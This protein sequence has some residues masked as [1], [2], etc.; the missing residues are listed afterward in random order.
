MPISIWKNLVKTRIKEYDRNSH[1]LTSAMYIKSVLF[2]K[3]VTKVKMWPW[4]IHASRY[5]ELA[6]HCTTL[7]RILLGMETESTDYK[8]ISLC[9]CEYNQVKTVEH[10]LFV[11]K[12]LKSS[13][14]HYWKSVV[15]LAPKRLFDD[16]NDMSV[17]SKT[18]FLISGFG[19][20]YVPEF[21]L[22]YT[23][24]LMYIIQM[25]KCSKP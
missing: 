12:K 18:I 3:C 20:T 14:E 9:D 1:I 11:C 19:G 15:K 6:K 24:V 4:Y 16:L 21:H 2:V 13:R 23:A 5:P 7:M 10:I 8:N 25:I 17:N 22:L